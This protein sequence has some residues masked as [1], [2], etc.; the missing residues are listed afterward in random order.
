MYKEEPWRTS[1]RTLPVSKL[2]DGQ[3]CK[4]QCIKSV[5]S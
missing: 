2:N 1:T 5:A 3:A 4:V